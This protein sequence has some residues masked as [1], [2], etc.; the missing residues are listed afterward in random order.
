[1]ALKMF[2][3]MQQSRVKPGVAI[4]STVLKACTML[5]TLNGGQILH[6]QMLQDELAIDMNLENSLIDMYGKCGKLEDAHYVFDRMLNRDV[7]SWNSLISVYVKHGHSLFPIGLFFQMEAENVI[8]CRMTY[9]CILKACSNLEDA[10][11]GRYIHQQLVINGFESDVIVVNALI[12]MYAKCGMLRDAEIAFN[13]LEHKTIVSW[14][15]IISGYATQGYSMISLRFFD[16]MLKYGVKPNCVILAATLKACSSS[17]AKWHG[18]FVHYCIVENSIELETIIGNSLL[19]IYITFGSLQ[20]AYSVFERLPH[21]D[22]ISWNTMISAYAQ[23]GYHQLAFQLFEKMQ[24]AGFRV[25]QPL[26][27]S[28]IKSCTTLR[29]KLHGM[30]LHSFLIETGEG[31]DVMILNTFVSMYANCGS[32]E[33]AQKIFDTLQDRSLVSWGALISGYAAHGRGECALNIL[34]KMQEDGVEPNDVIYLSILSVYISRGDLQQGRLVHDQIVRAELERLPLVAHTIIHLYAHCGSLEEGLNIF[35]RLSIHDEVS[36]G[37]IMDGCAQNEDGVLA[38]QLFQRMQ[39]EGVETNMVI[40]IIALKSCGITGSIQQGHLVHNQVID[41]GLEVESEIGTTLID[42]YGSCGYLREAHKVF[43][44]LHEQD[45]CSWNA[46]I[47][48]YSQHGHGKLALQC[49]QDMQE[50]HL[51][52]DAWTFTS[53]LAAFSHE[54]QAHSCNSTFAQIQSSH[55]HIPRI[56]HLN[57]VIDNWSRIGCLD[58]AERL[59]QTMPKLPN[60]IG[61]LALLTACRTF[62]CNKVGP[63]IVHEAA[64]LIPEDDST[65][66]PI[67]NM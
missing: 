21:K 34:F 39:E 60:S 17:N 18:M 30:F 48:G 23:E 10:R 46:L 57:C 19:E 26:A 50:Q 65:S 28:L 3:R 45:L 1:M 5:K 24:R 55:G 27:I 61:W 42:M 52:P 14:G 2:E 38:F 15:A 54:G 6:S 53:V 66:A 16:S 37:I 25:H 31:S 11:I 8:P 22:D 13:N 47:A 41:C 56:E 32:L 4:F 67:S 35:D 33:D 51:Q 7:V 43:N 64:G 36:W 29:G 20:D 58:E 63:K 59:L 12:N 9:S 49:I 44:M 62:G 40:F